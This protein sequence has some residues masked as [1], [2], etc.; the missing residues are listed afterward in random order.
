MNSPDILDE[1]IFS[2][3]GEKSESDRSSEIPKNHLKN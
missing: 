2:N 1:T 3:S